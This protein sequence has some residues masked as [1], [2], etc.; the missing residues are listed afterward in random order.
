MAKTGSK[1]GEQALVGGL[2]LISRTWISKRLASSLKISE[3]TVLSTKSTMAGTISGTSRENW[4]LYGWTT[5]LIISLFFRQDSIGVVIN[6]IR[7]LEN[8][9]RM[10][11]QKTIISWRYAPS[12]ARYGQQGASSND[13][14]VKKRNAER[15][16]RHQGAGNWSASKSCQQ[17]IKT[18]S[19]Q[20]L[21]RFQKRPF[22]CSVH[23]LYEWKRNWI[24]EPTVNP[25][26]E[27]SKG[28][29]AWSLI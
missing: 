29:T 13:G 7:K 12:V 28:T 2:Y 18:M 25:S 4:R 21:Y 17:V 16:W 27:K 20:D 5:K 15:P 11:T 19:D 23:D 3:E 14:R 1:L 9:T 6:M 26:T 10:K 8:L 24:D 22:G